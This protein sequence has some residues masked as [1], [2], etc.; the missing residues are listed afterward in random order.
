MALGIHPEL[1]KP[2]AGP[3]PTRPTGRAA[4][5]QKDLPL[6]A[7]WPPVLGFHQKRSAVM[8]GLQ[9]GNTAN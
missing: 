3:S 5:W 2:S 7:P 4:A 1:A 8:Y 6:V 9:A